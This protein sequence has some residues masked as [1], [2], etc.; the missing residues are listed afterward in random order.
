MQLGI[1]LGHAGQDQHRGLDAGGAQA[2][3]HVVAMHIG[4]QQVK[5]DDV[6]IVEL[7]DLEP[8]FAK[9]GDVYH[10]ALGLQHQIDGTGD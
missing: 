5:Q 8:V 7:A 1:K 2:A 3:Q 6:V 10:E 4:Q 9:V